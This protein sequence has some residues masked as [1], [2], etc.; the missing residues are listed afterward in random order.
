[1]TT[2]N[3]PSNVVGIDPS[4]LP[5]LEASLSPENSGGQHPNLYDS[6]AQRVSNILNPSGPVDDSIEYLSTTTESE[7]TPVV[8]LMSTD[9]FG[10][11]Q[12]VGSVS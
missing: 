4:T 6:L 9:E 7:P 12:I 8:F 1:M 3:A 11:P 2:E 5:D 10:S